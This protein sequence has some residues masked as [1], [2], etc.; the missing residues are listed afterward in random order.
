MSTR[1]KTS[2]LRCVLCGSDEKVQ[3][4]HVGG[5]HHVA[6]FTMPFCQVHHK[7]FH[8]LLPN[9]LFEHTPDSNE[10]L[11][12]ALK[13]ISVC[14]WMLSESVSIQKSGGDK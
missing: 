6:W 13:A 10:R 8:S 14:L 9:T 1:T 5:Q 4:N 3:R 12:R 7:Q 11:C 2:G